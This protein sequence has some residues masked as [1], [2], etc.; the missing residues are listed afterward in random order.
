MWYGT[1]R[2]GNDDR[3]EEW[4]LSCPQQAMAAPL[5]RFATSHVDFIRILM[6][7]LELDHH[8]PRS[9]SVAIGMTVNTDKKNLQ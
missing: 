1:V 5:L 2:D 3:L 8:S 6:V 4:G 9:I 7:L